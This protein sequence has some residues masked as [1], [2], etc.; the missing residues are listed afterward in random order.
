MKKGKEA[1]FWNDVTVDMMSDEEK[2]DELYVRHQ[3]TYRSNTLNVFIKKLD[4]RSAASSTTHSKFQRIIGT[5]VKKAVPPSTK[6]WIVRPMS[7]SPKAADVEVEGANETPA[8]E[9]GDGDQHARDGAQQSE[10]DDV[11]QSEPESDSEE[12]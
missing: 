8:P 3:P 7:S 1:K 11:L 5:P 9:H 2:R 12:F 4:E 10:S 6:K